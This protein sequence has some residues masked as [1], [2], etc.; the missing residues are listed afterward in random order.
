MKQK[1][2]LWQASRW[3]WASSVVVAPVLSWAAENAELSEIKV[4]ATADTQE[5]R[6][7]SSAGKMIFDRKELEASNAATVGELL[8]KLPG[9]GMF[10]DAQG[11]PP[12][13]GQNRGPSRNMP[14]ILVDGQQM[15]GGNP[16]TTFRL[17]VEMIERVEIIRNS[18]PEFQ[19]SSPAGVINIIMRDVPPKP[20]RNMKLSLGATDGEPGAALDGQ[21]SNNKGNLGYLLSGS[22]STRPNVGSRES[23]ITTYSAGVVSNQSVEKTTQEGDDNNFTF[24]P[25]LNWKL[26]QGEQLTISPFFSYSEMQRDVATSRTNNT[27]VQELEKNDGERQ[28]GRLMGEWKKQGQQGSEVSIRIMAQVEDEDTAKQTRLIDGFGVITTRQAK[29]AAQEQEQML[30]TRGKYVFADAHL[31]TGALELRNRNNED[32]QLRQNVPT[33]SSIDEQR[34]VAWIQDEWQISEQHLLTPGFRWQRMN[35]TITDSQI[36]QLDNNQTTKAPSLHY[37]WQ[38][39]QVWNIRASIARTDRPAFAR[40]LSP[41]VRTSTGVNDSGNPDR[42]GNPQLAVEEQQSIELGVEHFLAQKAGS[43]G[44]SVYERRTDSYVQRLTLQESGRWVERP[45]NVGDSRIRGLVFDA[46]AR[47]DMISLPDLT[48][49]TNAAYSDVQM[50]SQQANLGA[51][52]GPRK[53]ANLGFDYELKAYKLTLG[54]SLSYISAVDRES[55]A[56]VIQQQGA[57]RFVVAY[58]LYKYNRQTSVRLAAHNFTAQDREEVL[59]EYNSGG[60]LERTEVDNI[61]GVVNYSVSVET[62]W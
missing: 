17:P 60:L 53:S 36:G 38:P 37:L 18:T 21:L 46:K 23:V 32:K 31:L 24:S 62:R 34:L 10:S 50:L 41:A 1:Q 35:S 51:G 8:S 22:A 26:A 52:E 44:L 56:T 16:A 47:M 43:L 55:S 25:R 7:T 11:G 12:R 2:L 28:T 3:V 19:V 6:R 20:M 30:E 14:Q 13:R 39:N 58:A 40:D 15:P 42:A 61:P 33:T 54:S 57:Q 49:R 27:V 5:E 29:T 48:I 9:T 59:R 4:T 45:Y